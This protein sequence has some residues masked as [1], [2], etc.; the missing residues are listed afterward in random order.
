MG[1]GSKCNQNSSSRDGGRLMKLK[2]KPSCWNWAKKYL[3]AATCG[4]KKIQ[5]NEK[6]ILHVAR[7]ML[8]V[9]SFIFFLF[10]ASSVNKM[11]QLSCRNTCGGSGEGAAWR[12][13]FFQMECKMNCNLPLMKMLLVVLLL[14]KMIAI[15]FPMIGAAPASP[16]GRRR[17]SRQ[18]D[19][20]PEPSHQ[21]SSEMAAKICIMLGR[22]YSKIS[23]RHW[24]KWSGICQGKLSSIRSRFF[25]NS[26]VYV[27]QS[28]AVSWGIFIRS[29][30][31]IYWIIF[32][33]IPY[34]SAS[35]PWIKLYDPYF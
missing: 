2:S 10:D 6:Q 16:R 7:C 29:S 5:K 34:Q 25:K 30:S 35:K 11:L 19:T 4:E 17:V 22:P 21:D 27:T 13:A 15:S 28:K 18:P 8:H 12:Q 3:E 24:E 31:G 20:D 33:R 32:R 1:G 14:G 23:Y 9:A 26:R